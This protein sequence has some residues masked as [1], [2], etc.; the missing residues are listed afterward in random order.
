MVCTSPI[1][2]DKYPGKKFRCRKCL[3]CRITKRQEW[4][5]RAV[6]EARCYEQNS[7]LTLTFSDE[8]LPPQGVNVRD[9]QLFFK[10][11]RKYLSIHYPGKKIKYIACGEYGEKLMRPHYHILLFNFDFEDKKY[12]KR[13]RKGEHIYRSPTLEKL[14]PYG[15]SSIGELTHSSASYVAGYVHKKFTNKNI[16]EVN[17]HY[18]TLY[19]EVVNPEFIVSSNGI[20]KKFFETNKKQLFNQDYIIYNG[21][22][23]PLFEYYNRLME[24][25]NPEKFSRI[26]YRRSLHIKDYSKEELEARAYILKKKFSKR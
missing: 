21:V 6:F 8:Y 23:Y 5:M 16:E 3:A 18:T 25:E 17:K 11:L 24:N 1:T 26:K 7:F 14:W 19:G 20:A 2:L 13:T 9:L 12:L 22:K 4:A 15:I 10:R